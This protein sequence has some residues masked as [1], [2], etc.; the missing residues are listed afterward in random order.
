MSP[1]RLPRLGSVVWAEL[2]VG[3]VQ[4]VVGILPPAVIGELLAKVAATL[5]TP[6]ANP[7][8]GPDDPAS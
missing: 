1:T 6:P 3:D 5:T 2:W 8:P 4:Q 7:D